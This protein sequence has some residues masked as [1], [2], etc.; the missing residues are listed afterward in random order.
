MLSMKKKK[1]QFEVQFNL[2]ELSSVPFVSG[3]LYA[4]VRLIDGGQFTRQSTRYDF[5]LAR[6]VQDNKHLCFNRVEIDNHRVRWNCPFSFSCKLSA[7]AS[8]GILDTCLCRVSVRKVSSKQAIMCGCYIL[9]LLCEAANQ[10]DENLSIYSFTL[11][12]VAHLIA[13]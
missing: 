11:Y 12:A 2:Q 13:L 1:F 9:H 3:V 6:L 7:N 5:W 8:S 4:K 10:I